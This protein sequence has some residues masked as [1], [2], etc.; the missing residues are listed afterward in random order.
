MCRIILIADD[1]AVF[2]DLEAKVL[3]THGY[4]VIHASNGAETLRKAVEEKPDL[5]LLDIQMP[6]MDGVQ[7]L[8]LLKKQPETKDIPVF[9]VSTIGRVKDREI[10]L[11]GGADEFISKPIN[12]REM[13][14]R[15]Q[16]HL[17]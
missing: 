1:S 5:I 17:G 9:V 8:A 3:E 4:H 14:L 16:E 10:L 6:V 13:L 2:R 12:I 7:T 11:K 15:I